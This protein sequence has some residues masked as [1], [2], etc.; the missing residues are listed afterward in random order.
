MQDG[1]DADQ[2]HTDGAQDQ[3]QI[4]PPISPPPSTVT[5]D[6]EVRISGREAEQPE[7]EGN[8][9][10]TCSSQAHA[11]ESTVESMVDIEESNEIDTASGVYADHDKALV[12]S[13]AQAVAMTHNHFHELRAQCR[14]M[15]VVFMQNMDEMEEFMDKHSTYDPE[16]YSTPEV[17]DISSEE[18]KSDVSVWEALIVKVEEMCEEFGPCF[19]AAKVEVE[20][21]TCMTLMC[22]HSY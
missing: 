3:T 17:S 2:V 14:A 5:L 15:A 22:Q 7:E 9:A 11:E 10:G 18:I 8:E 21:G 19:E 4:S 13:L 6:D 16:M 12:N 1:E 20:K